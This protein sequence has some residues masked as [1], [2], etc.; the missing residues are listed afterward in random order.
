MEA[1]TRRS[2][3]TICSIWMESSRLW[4]FH[5]WPIRTTSRTTLRAL[6]KLGASLTFPYQGDRELELS[7]LGYPER[8][9]MREPGMAAST[10]PPD[11]PIATPSIAIIGTVEGLW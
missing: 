2:A 9:R 4:C 8:G 1:S 3:P 6:L 7:P 10:P 5:T 11:G